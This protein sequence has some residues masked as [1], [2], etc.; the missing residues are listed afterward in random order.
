MKYIFD[1][2]R[3]LRISYFKKVNHESYSQFGEDKILNEIIK[4]DHMDGFY[5]DVGCFHPKKYSNTYILH[6]RGWS[7]INIDVE[8]DK[9]NTFNLTRK[10]DVNILTAVS[11]SNKKKTVYKFDKYSV[12]TRTNETG[13]LKFN[14]EIKD[15]YSIDSMSLNTI[16]ENSK[17]NGK[18]IDLLNIDIEGNDLDA[19]K[20]LDI[21]KYNPK[22]I[23]IESHCVVISDIIKSD[24]YLYLT[25]KNYSLRS[26]CFYS[27]VFVKKDTK[28]IRNR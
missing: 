22:I 21:I 20:S 10:N 19:L 15:S 17:F 28:S 24:I 14:D 16:I 9:I 27:L 1:K 23:I 3:L 4:K 5:I 26:W 7:G 2:L 18:E 13:K 11:T 12:N 6:R 25:T 8:K